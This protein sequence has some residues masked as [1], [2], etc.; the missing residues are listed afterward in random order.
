MTTKTKKTLAAVA[1]VLLALALVFVAPVGATGSPDDRGEVCDANSCDHIAEYAG[2]HYPTLENALAQ[3]IVSDTDK[4]VTII[5]APSTTVGFGLSSY[6]DTESN[7]F[8]SYPTLQNLPH[9]SFILQSSPGVILTNNIQS[10]QG[11]TQFKDIIFKNL[12]FSNGAGIQFLPATTMIDNVTIQD[13]EFTNLGSS[14]AIQ[15]HADSTDI[16]ENISIKGNEISTDNIG[17]YLYSPGFVKGTLTIDNNIIESKTTNGMQIT[18]NAENLVITNNKIKAVRPVNLAGITP[19]C[20]VTFTDNTITFPSEYNDEGNIIPTP[21]IYHV[22]G[23]IVLDD[24]N[25]FY[26]TDN[27]DVTAY[28]SLMKHL[29]LDKTDA[30][31]YVDSVKDSS[32][33]YYGGYVSVGLN[34]PK[35]ADGKDTGVA[36][37]DVTAASLNIKDGYSIAK[38]H[39]NKDAGYGYH[40]IIGKGAVSN[41]VMK[42][43]AGNFVT[44]PSDFVAEGYVCV[45]NGDGT[46]T[47]TD[48]THSISVSATSVNFGTFTEGYSNVAGGNNAVSDVTITV[49]NTGNAN[50]TLKTPIYEGTKF[51]VSSHSD[52]SAEIEPGAEVTFTILPQGE[53]TAGTHTETITIQAIPLS[54]SGPNGEFEVYDEKVIT[55]TFTVI[56]APEEGETV[57]IPKLPPII[58]EE[59]DEGTITITVPANHG[60]VEDVDG[61]SYLTFSESSNAQVELFISGYTG[62]I[63]NKYSLDS[64]AEIHAYYYPED[65]E[66]TSEYADNAI[67][68]GVELDLKKVNATLPTFSLKYDDETAAKV[69]SKVNNVKPIAM[70]NATHNAA[71]V[72]ADLN[73]I[74]LYFAMDKALYEKHKDK[75]V[76]YHVGVSG[77]PEIVTGEP[78]VDKSF[79]NEGVIT[80]IFTSELG[81]SS[82]VLAVD[83]TPAQGG[84]NTG[85]NNQD[86]GKTPNYNGGGG[87]KKPTTVTPTV[88][89]TEEPTDD[90]TDVPGEQVPETPETPEQPETPATPAPVLAVLAGLGAAVVLRRK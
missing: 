13:C 65:S 60:I 84:D 79:E 16:V 88:P 41:D 81:F 90:P 57:L 51:I 28:S 59:N 43:T 30:A 53:L 9:F 69:T 12:T 46:F 83:T 61:K 76:L 85:N 42:L 33:S 87:G 68:L 72:D 34:I 8:S 47:V 23:S 89:P 19:N 63:N 86:T 66:T 2:K 15:I 1:V 27:T 75:F 50:V 37:D 55:A 70:L 74:T 7:S 44:D 18:W 54:S 11:K 82:Y 29:Y 77:T 17:V 24:S 80:L 20:K 52:L 14:H 32:G 26:Y 21:A 35:G 64:D 48:E 40:Y 36:P 56:E 3:A 67:R 38:V 25:K 71:A 5:N 6:F 49:E 39:I 31:I 62:G 58:I 4:V 10:G 73:S 45:N 22:K 78:D